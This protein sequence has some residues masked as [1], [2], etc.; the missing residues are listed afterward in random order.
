MDRDILGIIEERIHGFSKGKQQIATYILRNPNEASF[1]TA[2]VIGKAVG[3]PESSVVRFAGDLGFKG[4]PEFQ[5]ALQKVAME[6]LRDHHRLPDRE[7]VHSN[8]CPPILT[9]AVAELQQCRRL[10]F[11]SDSLGSV[12][13]LY[14]KLW[15][16]SAGASI[17]DLSSDHAET[18][19]RHLSIIEPGDLLLVPVFHKIS[20]LLLFAIEQGKT[21]GARIMVLTDMQEFPV[22]VLP[23]ILL[24]IQL[25]ESPM[26]P[27][28]AP[29][30]TML[31][32]MF[33]QWCC[34]TEQNIPKQMRIYEEIRNAYENRKF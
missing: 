6:Q 12:L 33:Y 2:A 23:D 4:F 16:D 18:L 5:K 3:V 11:L 13:F 10:W 8:P 24:P 25:K 7:D 22:T 27:D 17:T 34:K 31:S 29:A 28:L 20:P 32:A 15:C 19:F 1:Q 21:L 14:C 9:D 26:I 30:M